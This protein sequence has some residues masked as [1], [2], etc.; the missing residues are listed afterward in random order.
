MRF[1]FSRL[2]LDNT[3]TLAL[4]SPALGC[5]DTGWLNDKG[6]QGSGSYVYHMHLRRTF[7]TLRLDIHAL[8]KLNQKAEA[9]IKKVMTRRRPDELS[10]EALEAAFWLVVGVRPQMP[11]MD[12]CRLQTISQRRVGCNS[13]SLWADVSANTLKN[14]LWIILRLALVDQDLE[15]QIY[16]DDKIFLTARPA[17]VKAWLRKYD[18]GASNAPS[19]AVSE[20]VKSGMYMHSAL[21]GDSRVY[22]GAWTDMIG[23]PRNLPTLVA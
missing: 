12:L 17:A 16:Y 1:T 9:P 4:L 23:L 13:P 3:V 5:P 22:C 14:T 2:A 21:I 10:I 20:I 11:K 8:S 6:I 15:D 7:V 18:Q 19:A